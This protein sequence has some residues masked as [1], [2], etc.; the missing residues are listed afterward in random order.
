[1]S[2]ELVQ[3][4]YDALSD[5]KKRFEQQSQ[6]IQEMHVMIRRA[7]DQ[8]QNGG[9]IGGGADAFYAEMEDVVEPAIRRLVAA[10][11][12]GGEVT[13][14][15]SQKLSEADQQAAAPIQQGPEA[16]MQG[17]N[18]AG[19]GGSGAGGAWSEGGFS[20]PNSAALDRAMADQGF[21]SRSSLGGGS[22]GG[23]AGGIGGI[24]GGGTAGGLGAGS[25]SGTPASA[26]RQSVGAGGSSGGAGLG[27]VAYQAGGFGSGTT[28]TGEGMPSARAAGSGAASAAVQA[29]ASAAGIGIPMGLAAL[30]PVAALVG[31][32]IKD[33]SENR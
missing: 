20:P 16:A 26:G 5:T 2:P 9:W 11:D 28:G 25:G 4:Q 13:A 30:S 15:T 31:K 7:V 14:G 32:A 33:K 19:L 8:L 10:L 6:A 18:Y 17:K 1:M 22:G 27:A 23:T 29:P 21:G 12:L 3:V 24:P